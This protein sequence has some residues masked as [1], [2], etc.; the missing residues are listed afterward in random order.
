MF[1]SKYQKKANEILALEET[2]K[3]L[4]DED[5]KAKTEEFKKKVADGASL[6]SILVEAYAVA[7][8]GA[9]R[10]TGLSAYP[11]QLMGGIV[12]HE[13]KIAEQKTGEGKSLTALFP[14]YLNA[15]TG[16]GVHV[17]TVNDYLAARDAKEIGD[18][19]RFLGLTVGCVTQDMY[20][21]QRKKEY[22]C[23][24]TYIT[25]NEL[26]FDYLRDNMAHSVDEIVQRGLHYAVIDEVDSI[27]ID[28]ARTPL[29]ISMAGR[30]GTKLYEACAYLASILERGEGNGEINKIDIMSGIPPQEDG[31][32]LVNEKDKYV[33]LTA[34]GVKKVES[35][36]GIENISDP[37]NLGIQHGIDTALKAKDL[38]HRD[39]DYIVTDKKEVMIVDE[40]TGRIMPGRRFSDGLHQALEAKEHVPIQEESL[41]QATITFQNFFNKYEKK[42]GMTGTAKTEESEFKE[43][44]GMPVVVIPTNKPVIRQD[45]V[46]AIYLTKK[47]KYKAIIKEIEERHAKGQPILVG[48]R[49]LDVSE[50]LDEMLPDIPHQVLN[51]KHHKEEAE[52]VSHAGER[53]MVTIATNMAG[54]GTDIKLGEGVAELGGLH[55]I[56]VERN[57]SRRIDNQLRGRAGRQGDP[58]SSKFY[59]SFED[60]LFKNYGA[61]R[62]R[63]MAERF[64]MKEE[65]DD[66]PIESKTFDKA[67]NKAQKKLEANNFDIRKNLLDYDKVNNDQREIVYAERNKILKGDSM[68]GQ[69]YRMIKGVAEDD[70]KTYADD[71]EALKEALKTDVGLYEFERKDGESVEDAEKRAAKKALELYH[72]KEGYFG[73]IFSDD[74]NEI[75]LQDADTGAEATMSSIR[76]FERHYLLQNID[77]FW[78]KQIADM[79]QLRQNIGLTSY[80]G[81]DPVAQYTFEGCN[82]FDE[83]TNNIRKS[84]VRMI[85][86]LD[87]TPIEVM[88]D[89]AV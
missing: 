34:Q 89:T 55:I 40:F 17:V 50:V 26:G 56:G 27:L 48:T 82:M 79:D 86:A 64:G 73:E 61:E 10:V 81:K 29:I 9:R 42:C 18:I 6:D 33:L 37:K 20:P 15:L 24:I 11:V 14:C 85:T 7:R 63:K 78:M 68:A 69:T 36:F 58:G 28:E 43:V 31:D 88:D 65:K 41:T 74:E 5:L 12:L 2:M 47:G 87:L 35:F 84:F 76:D 13:G 3:S 77:A 62:M 70:V 83:M 21:F 38:F 4:S 46:D 72:K 44:Y 52:I 45:D 49:S 8:E 66:E 59:L 67:F 39:R 30:E 23:D 1:L 71:P 22:A 16:Q 51:A 25:N 32:Y 53:G 75:I 80:A 57:E 54:R 19:H 60:D